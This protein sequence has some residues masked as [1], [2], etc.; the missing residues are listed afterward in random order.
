MH[1]VT[2]QNSMG[3]SKKVSRC[4]NGGFGG[5]C[6]VATIYRDSPVTP[7][8]VRLGPLDRVHE[9]GGERWRRSVAVA[10]AM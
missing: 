2:A 9:S 10:K 3:A 6:R 5:P 4:R 7:A 1:R 8:C